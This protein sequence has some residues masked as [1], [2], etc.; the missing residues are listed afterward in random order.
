MKTNNCSQTIGITQPKIQLNLSDRNMTWLHCAGMAGLWMTLKQLEKRFPILPQRPGQL[1]WV[2]SSCSISLH[3]SGCDLEVLDWLLKQSFQINH[4]GLISLT[5]LEHQ[6]LSIGTQVAIHQGITS[7]F[8]QHNKFYKLDEEKRLSLK[9]GRKTIIVRYKGLASYAHQEFAKHLCNEQGQLSQNPIQIAGWLYPGA[10]MSHAAFSKQTKFEVSLN[11][12]LT[13]LFAPVA[14]WYFMV[15][16]SLQKKRTQYVLVI[17][18]I[19]DLEVYAE[20]Y[21]TIRDSNYENFWVASLGDAGLNFLVLQESV[22]SAESNKIRRCRSILFGKSKWLKQ[23]VTRKRIETIEVTKESISHYELSRKYFLKKTVYQE[24]EVFYIGVSNVYRIIANNLSSGLPWWASFAE[25]TNNADSFQEIKFGREEL[26]CMIEEVQWD[27]QAKKLFIKACHEALRRIYAKL[28]GRAS[29]GEY[30][31]I[32]RRNTRIRSEL[33]R[34]KN[35]VT[36]RRFLSNFF[37]EAG[38][39]PTL[40]EHW[41]ELLPIMTGEIDWQLSRDLLLL[42]LASYKKSETIGNGKGLKAR[43][44]ETLQ[45]D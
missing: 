40:Q 45:I 11:E 20:C 30:I 12:A 33:G 39:V 14:C 29:E 17:P 13:L 27:D 31:Q 41:E 44:S 22:A 7:T 9:V 2:L 15:L 1:D 36:F 4:E 38:Q 24:N 18:E 5:G 25:G 42:A 35:A 16:L 26:L 8:L 3:W 19:N 10:V 28:Y 21:R 34:C 37:S 43:D 23:Q 32:E 6:T